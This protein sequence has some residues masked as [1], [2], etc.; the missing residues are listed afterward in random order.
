MIEWPMRLQKLVEWEL[1]VE[2]EV[3]GVNLAQWHFVLHEFHRTLD[4]T[5]A[6]KKQLRFYTTVFEC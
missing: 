2:F 6:G 4:R 5:R 3:L 1:A